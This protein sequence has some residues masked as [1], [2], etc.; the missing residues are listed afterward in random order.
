MLTRRHLLASASTLCAATAFSGQA[1]AAAGKKPPVARVEP[2]T[3]T[4]FGTPVTDPYRWMENKADK[5]WE[6]YMKGQSDFARAYFNGLPRRDALAK[7]INE[8]SGDLVAV[9]AMDVAGPYVLTEVRPQGANNFKLMVREG[10]TG[11]DRVLID[12]EKL[13]EGSTHYSMDY[14]AASPDGKYVAYGLSPSGSENTVIRILEIA[15]G[16]VLPETIDRAQYAS[17][18][19]LPDSSGFFLN[20]LA[21][22]AKPGSTDY[23]KRSVCWLHRPGT[24]PKTDVKVLAQGQYGDVAI[25]DIEFPGVYPVEGSPYVVALLI[26]GVQRELTIF[27][28]RLADLLAGKPQ[29]KKAASPSDKVTNLALMGDDLYLMTYDGAPRF[30]VLKVKAGAP[31]LAKAETVVPQGQ[32]VIQN[33]YTAKDGIYIEALDGGIG[34]L[35]KLDASGTQTP[36]ALPFDGAISWVNAHPARAGVFVRTEGWVNPAQILK[37]EAGGAVADTGL[38]PKPAIDLSGFQAIRV[39]VPA[40]DGTKVPLS[41]VKAKGTKRDGGAPAL[42]VAYGAYGINM[43]PGFRPRNLAFLE[44]GGV[45]AMAHVRGGGEFGKE[46]HDAGRKLTKANTWRDMIACAEYMIAEKWSGK[47]KIAIAGGSAGGITVGRALTER[48]DLFAVVISQVGVSNPLRAEFGQ[49]GPPNVPE[50]GTVKEEDGFKALLGMDSLNAVKD[51]TAY[52]A[53]ILT[54]GMTD[55]RVDPWHAGKM[56]ARLQ[57]ATSSGKPVLLRVEYGGGHGLG[58]TRKQLDQEWADIFAFIFQQTA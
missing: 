30:K 22:G 6:P 35:A 31:D 16:K 13:S 34:R 24:D 21:E 58:S 23:Y 19:W 18:A 47:G 26:A 37:V 3:E 50:F 2:V 41:I 12:P 20:R 32:A 10:L 56:A 33:V 15:T 9:A 45:W 25:N 7:R 46:W 8:L 54:T 53:V 40:A 29:W 17:I 28:A 27:T 5:D 4:F 36:I 44:A 52:P 48:P 57:K 43:V 39:M 14:W 38:S 42:I 11:T 49:N 51:G 55:P 1:F